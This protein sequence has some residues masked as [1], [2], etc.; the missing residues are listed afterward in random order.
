[1]NK[2]VIAAAVVGI[3]ILGACNSNAEE[4]HTVEWYLASENAEALD[5][6]IRECRNNPGELQNTPNCIN[7]RQAFQKRSTSGRFQ[8]VEEPPIPK[9]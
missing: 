3:M 4:T 8:K 9:F 1:M 7:A 2:L 6:K 5:A